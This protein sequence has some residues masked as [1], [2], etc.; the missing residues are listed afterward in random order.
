MDAS[1]VTL[2]VLTPGETLPTISYSADEG[3]SGSVGTVWA[4]GIWGRGDASSAALLCQV[5]NRNRT[6]L[7]ATT[8]RWGRYRDGQV[9]R[10]VDRFRWD[11]GRR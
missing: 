1:N 7:S 9:L 8:L 4:D 6:G 3:P 5:G 2:E 10:L 11:V